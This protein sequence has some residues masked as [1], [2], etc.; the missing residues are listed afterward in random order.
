MQDQ[1]DS[2]Q[3]HQRGAFIG[4]GDIDVALE[5]AEAGVPREALNGAETG[6][7]LG[8]GGGQGTAEG[9]QADA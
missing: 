8:H 9:V 5:L 3:L 7:A 4:L 1:G 6:A 2:T